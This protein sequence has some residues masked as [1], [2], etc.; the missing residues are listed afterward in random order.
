MNT[1]FDKKGEMPPL[2][3][4]TVNQLGTIIKR[5][6]CSPKIKH[7]RS[8]IPEQKSANQTINDIE[9]EFNLKKP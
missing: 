9:S 5:P 4:H 7:T 8:I 2:L 1:Q 6:N 3:K